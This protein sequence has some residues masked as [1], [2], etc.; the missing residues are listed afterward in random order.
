LGSSQR[1][2]NFQHLDGIFRDVRSGT[3]FATTSIYDT[4]IDERINGN[5]NDV[6]AT[7]WRSS[8]R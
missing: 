2:L 8:R 4:E 5:G 7:E 1:A 6:Y 3:A